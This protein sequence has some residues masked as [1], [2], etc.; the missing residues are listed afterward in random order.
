MTTE[1]THGSRAR[2]AGIKYESI[3][4]YRMRTP[5]ATIGTA[6]LQRRARAILRRVQRSRRPHLVLTRNIPQA[7]FLGIAAYERMERELVRL[8]EESRIAKKV[9]QAEEDIR[10]GKVRGCNL[11]SLLHR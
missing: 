6:D 4:M 10:R 9:R 5:T 2:Y 8:R 3:Q 1:L 7:V 11:R